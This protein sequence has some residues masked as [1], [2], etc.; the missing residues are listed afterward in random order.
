M[1]EFQNHYVAVKE[2]RNYRVQIAWFQAYDV[3]EEK[4]T[5]LWG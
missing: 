1:D 3:L 5:D 4:D 2:A